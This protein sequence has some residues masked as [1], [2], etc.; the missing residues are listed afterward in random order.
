MNQEH[1]VGNHHV[2]RIVR[3]LLVLTLGVMTGCAS[4][5]PVPQTV[6]YKSGLNQVHLE[7]DPDS[8][9]NAHPVT[10][11]T[12]EVG[13]L[14]RGVRVSDRRNLIHRLYAG[15]AEP[16]RAFREEEIKVVAPALS[17][18]LELASPDQRLYFH[19]SHVTEYGEEETTSGWLAIRDGQLHLALS[20]VH[21]RHSPGPDISKYDRQMPDVPELPPA[22]NVTFEPEEYLS[23]VRSRWRLFAPEQREELQI[24][25][26]DALAGLTKTPQP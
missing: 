21:D 6:V 25:Y 8:E 5:P 14:L 11:T 4:A 17:K 3:M 16:K 1:I 19:L 10:L 20:E 2:A 9:S 18:A 15:I 7:K 12:A 26:R 23:K 24:R 22:F 13:V